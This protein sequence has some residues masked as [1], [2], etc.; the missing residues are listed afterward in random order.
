MKKQST[1]ALLALASV[2]ALGSCAEAPEVKTETIVTEGFRYNESVCP[3]DGGILV[4]NF[5]CVGEVY[6]GRNTNGLGFINMYKDGVVTPFIPADGFLSA[7]KG[8]LIKDGYIL[9][10]DVNQL[11]AYKLDDLSAEPQILRFP[12]D[13]VVLNDIT[14]DGNTI[15]LSVSSSGRIYRL[16]GSDLS[17]IASIE[18]ELWL[19]LNGA[20]GV[21]IDKSTLY[22]CTFAQTDELE[23]GNVIYKITDLENP[24]PEVIINRPN[25][26][27]G[28]AIS[29]DGKKLY[30]GGW[31]PAGIT[32]LDLET[33]QTSTLDIDYEFKTP[34]DFKL[35]DGV[36][37]IPDLAA[38]TLVIKKL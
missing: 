12:D 27:D 5:G 9:I 25:K 21:L 1:F 35:V 30:T 34:A 3:Y 18:P 10:C 36:L 38:S 37:Y 31:I 7:P 33:G 11:V 13:D 4:A 14:I 8:M 26:W 2:L 16:D 28:V 22:V 23:P 15:Y 29:E 6:N 32:V 19:N 20:N 24:V 17:D